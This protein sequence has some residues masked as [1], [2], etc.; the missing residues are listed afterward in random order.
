[1]LIF[2]EKLTPVKLLISDK[3]KVPYRP[4]H[5]IINIYTSITIQT[6]FKHYKYQSN[7]STQII[8]NL[9]ILIPRIFLLAPFTHVTKKYKPFS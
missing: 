9:S 3:I 4:F 5:T 7:I 8:L 1:M 2:L 6:V